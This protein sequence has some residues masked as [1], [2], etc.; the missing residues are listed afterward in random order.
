MNSFVHPTPVNNAKTH[1]CYCLK[2]SLDVYRCIGCNLNH[3]CSMDCYSKHLRYHGPVCQ[4]TA[5]IDDWQA[6]RC[7][8]FFENYWFRQHPLLIRVIVILFGIYPTYFLAFLKAWK[9]L[10]P[11]SVYWCCHGKDGYISR[12]AN[13]NPFV[14]FC[15]SDPLIYLFHY[16]LLSTF[17]CQRGCFIFPFHI[18]LDNGPRFHSISTRKYCFISSTFFA[19][20]DDTIC[21]LPFFFCL[22]F[23]GGRT[24]QTFTIWHVPYFSPHVFTC[25]KGTLRLKK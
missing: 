23:I 2:N 16:L 12:Q 22:V 13:F 10:S 24:F 20:L 21:T 5:P 14:F 11:T 18:L 4:Q 3:Y 25:I 7:V 1:C 17:K 9:L 6:S 15:V 8:T 19:C